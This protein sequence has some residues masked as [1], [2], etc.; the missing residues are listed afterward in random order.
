MDLRQYY[1][2]IREIEA[3]ITETYPLVTSLATEDGGRAGVV[4]EVSRYQAARMIV[5]G[6]ARLASTEEKEGHAEQL[7]LAQKAAQELDAAR[8]VHMSLL[9]SSEQRITAQKAKP[10]GK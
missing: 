2:K 5:E 10:T 1:R 7:A 3:N 4:S 9:L 6:K 8:R